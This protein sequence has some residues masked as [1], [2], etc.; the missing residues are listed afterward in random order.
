MKTAKNHQRLFETGLKDGT[1]VTMVKDE[2][3]LKPDPNAK[4]AVEVPTGT[5]AEQAF[6]QLKECTK[7][8]RAHQVHQNNMYMPSQIIGG[9]V[10]IPRD[11]QLIK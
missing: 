9:E 4:I 5:I 10:I 3:A 11:E 1:K 2:E 8:F 7:K 6:E